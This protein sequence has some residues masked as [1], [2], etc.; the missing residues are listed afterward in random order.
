MQKKRL[1]LFNTESRQIEEI[2]ASN[3]KTLKMYTCGP[4][5]YNFAHIGNF[6]TYVFEDLL[7]RSLQFFGF[8][9]EQ[10]MNIT[11]VDDKTIRGAIE[12]KIS[13]N[14]FTEPFTKAFFE[15]LKTL[16][17]EPVEHYPKATDYIP[18]MIAIIQ[19]LL[20]KGIAYEG[21]DKSIYFAIR[22]FPSYGRLSHLHLGE[23]QTGASQRVA[24]DEYDKENAS[25]FVLWKAYDPERDGDIFWESPF[26]PGRPGWHI[27][28]S[29]MAM[30]LLGESIDIHVG[31]VDNMFPHHENEIAQS[32]GYSCCRFV[33]HWLHS[34]HLLVDH[35]KMSKSLG[36]FYTL[37]DLLA[38]GYTGRQVR[39]MLLQ[40]HY[41]TQ[42]NFTFV[43]LDAAV[44]SLQRL[45][46]FIR[47]LQ[48][49]RH[50]KM[51]RAL[52]LILDKALPEMPQKK[53]IR[54]RILFDVLAQKE[55]DILDPDLLAPILARS[56]AF[57]PDKGSIMNRI[58]TDV[59][60]EKESA[61]LKP[62]LERSL[63]GEGV[64]NVLL[65]NL[66][67]EV[68]DQKGS[69]ILDPNFMKPVLQKV[70]GKIPVQAQAM[71]T[72]LQDMK[73]KKN[74][75][76]VLPLLHKT[77]ESFAEALAEDLNISS[78]LAALFD[79]VREVN[80]LCDQGKIGIS[81]AE[82]I[83][84]FL[85]Q[86]DQILGVLPLEAEKESIPEELVAA[87]AKRESARAEKNWQ[88][89]D[90]CRTFI[91]SKGYVIEDTPQGARLKKQVMGE[92]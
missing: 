4:T 6:R 21:A 45:S 9:V 16:Y 36:N 85:R 86:I 8:K 91:Q 7:R 42:L 31:A 66:I 13:L 90:E 17:I 40:T 51:H 69:N 67:H 41:R 88:I 72:I 64:T 35:K 24:A 28:C 10:A 87:L 68:R 56:L 48:A 60:E 77:M 30:K 32:E 20:E 19:K 22:Q 49:L 2:H 12:K 55:R 82:D 39:Y 59:K 52:D 65:T 1:K 27:E 74:Y 62:V 44:S 46:D 43:G 25:D 34:E 11:D 76:F 14:A 47:R 79:M 15:D 37:R 84:D 78:A 23:L 18:E 89:A 71:E 63:K 83:L 75:G 26:G 61:L 81:E 80:A 29:A 50:E 38:K 73:L 92:R 53:Q 33:R 54:D 5:V 70:L 3:G 58:L 57:S